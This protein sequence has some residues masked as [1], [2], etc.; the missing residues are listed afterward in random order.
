M[1]QMACGIN[2][3][4]AAVHSS[5]EQ[6]AE[7]LAVCARANSGEFGRIRPYSAVLGRIEPY[8][9]GSGSDLTRTGAT[10]Q[11]WRQRRAIVASTCGGG[12]R[13]A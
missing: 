1:C 10:V 4:N 13:M 7:S 12:V 2:I 6:P 8:W 3:K 9:G 11:R 5:G